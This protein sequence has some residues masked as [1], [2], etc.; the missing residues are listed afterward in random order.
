MYLPPLQLSRNFNIS[1]SG[2]VTIDENAAIAPGAILHAASGCR[3]TI[4]AGVS[5]G[6]GA[7]IQAH[8]G[9]LTLESGATLGAGVLIIGSGK[10]G[11]NACIGTASTILNRSIPAEEM[12]N[13]GSLLGDES[14]QWADIPNGSTAEASPQISPPTPPD[15]PPPDAASSPTPPPLGMDEPSPNPTAN[16]AAPPSPPPSPP[17]ESGSTDPSEPAIAG[18]EHINRLLLTLF[19]HKNVA[20]PP[21]PDE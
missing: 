17:P 14:R 4:A 18:Q 1:V 3:I 7:I 5:I 6:M 8:G 19:P 13:P 10:I 21:L 9:S 12:V 16:G 15:S 20:P 11:A 2:D